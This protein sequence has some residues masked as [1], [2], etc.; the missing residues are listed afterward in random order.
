[1]IVLSGGF[2]SRRPTP[3]DRFAAVTKKETSSAE[4]V[5]ARAEEN[6]LIISEQIEA[7]PTTHFQAIVLVA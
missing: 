7:E 4:D 6:G 3:L 1:M 5:A 2:V